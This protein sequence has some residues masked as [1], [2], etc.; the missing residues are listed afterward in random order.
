MAKRT[1]RWVLYAALL[2]L[3]CA[4]CDAAGRHKVMSTL[5]DG[6]PA[7]PPAEEYCRDFAEAKK[8]EEPGTGS[9]EAPET[10]KQQKTSKHRPY[11]E[12]ACNDCHDQAQQN[13]LIRPQ[14]ELCFVCHKDF[15]QGTQVHGPV[16]VGECLACH[17]PHS[18]ANPSLLTAA[19]DE[20]CAICHQERR[21]AAGMHE[22]VG[23]KGMVCVDCHD[24]H[25]G[26]ARY[27]LK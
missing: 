1:F 18:A 24:P 25:F 10:V 2:V 8:T 17:K 11:E 15:I 6:Y 4:G 26:N 27:F 14:R 16:A 19:K 7:L 22:A 20:I 3:C 5:F 13:G 21:M 9:D 23:E 12:K